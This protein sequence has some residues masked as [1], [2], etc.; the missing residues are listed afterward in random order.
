MFFQKISVVV[1]FW[2]LVFVLL[3]ISCS[4]SDL[5]SESCG[6]VISKEQEA[7]VERHLSAMNTFDGIKTRGIRDFPLKVH[8]VRKSDRTGGMTLFQL[9]EVVENLNTLFINANIR[10][11]ILDNIHYI[12]D[13]ASYDFDTEYEERLCSKYDELNVINI[14]FFNS[15]RTGTE[16]ICG[17]TY[18]PKGVDRVLMAN[19]CAL[20]GST[21]PHEFGHYFMLYHTH[22][23]SNQGEGGE[24]ID[25]SNC[26][27]AGDK[28]CDTPADPNLSGKVSS[29]CN[30]E[31]EI[32]DKNGMRYTPDTY[33][34]M[35]YA[36]KK[37]RQQFTKGQLA[38]M[39]YTALNHRNYLRFPPSRP[40]QEA[41]V[42]TDILLSGE[43]IL[44]F[45]GQ[46]IQT[47]LDGNLYKSVAPFYSGTNYRLSIINNEAAYV[48]VLGSNKDNQTN[49]LF[50]RKEESALISSKGE[51]VDL[52]GGNYYFQM[53]D[54]KGEDYLIVLYSKK[55][56]KIQDILRQLKFKNGNAI[57]R[58]YRV[59]G[60]DVVPLS[61]VKY[62]EDGRLQFS[63]VT[64]KQTIVPIF[65]EIEHL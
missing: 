43:L 1:Q 26:M 61:D 41:S 39:N 28:V 49:L 6:T 3:Y 42:E 21:L 45:S 35:S 57:Q 7:F 32:T 18:F 59:L 36:P 65:V 11:I 56:L 46:K 33:N 14:Y 16:N 48:Y 27:S 30:Y 4:P 58:L 60:Q 9:K 8:I 63:A 51:R 40:N 64:Q 53:D 31:G 19:S 22:Q 24:L 62:S 23:G 17:Y 10:F 29:D 20:N 47:E 37:C 12:D 5:L 13:D 15:I 52:P 50:P 2:L 25:Q 55:P 54:T 34:I 38:R 44:E